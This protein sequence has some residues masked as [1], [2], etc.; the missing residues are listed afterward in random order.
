M[1]KVLCVMLPVV[2]LSTTTAFAADGTINFT[3]EITSAAC[4]VDAA[5]ANQNVALGTVNSSVFSGVGVVAAPTKFD[6][7]LTNCD[8]A[9]T[10][11]NVSFDGPADS[12]NSQLLALD[13]A[14]TAAGVG[15]A[16]Y[17]DD[18]TTLI[19]LATKSKSHSLNTGAD[20]TISYVAKYMATASSVTAGSANASTNFTVSYQ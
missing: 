15:I 2:A 8:A 6:I 20:T 1:K 14:S 11:V 3:G 16:L 9:V 19:P 12:N 5:S 18:A 17:E 10:S 7:T 13:G 4:T